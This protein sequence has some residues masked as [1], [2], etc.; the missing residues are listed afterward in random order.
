MEGQF[1]ILDNQIS[2]ADAEKDENVAETEGL[3][4]A[5]GADAKVEDNLDLFSDNRVELLD[6][7][8][9]TYGHVAP[10][11][12][13]IL[14]K[15]FGFIGSFIF[16]ALNVASYNMIKER[17]TEFLNW[18]KDF[19]KSGGETGPLLLTVIL[20]VLVGAF[21]L[22]TTLC[23]AFFVLRMTRRVHS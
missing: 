10:Q 12:F 1:D 9:V 15:G 16:I 8:V 13:W 21:Y 11:T 22:A 3:Q 4:K 20:N 7:E 14:I 17:T 19:D 6:E 5:D 18:I 2:P 23:V